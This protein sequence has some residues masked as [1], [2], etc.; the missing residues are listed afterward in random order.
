MRQDPRLFDTIENY[1]RGDLN[2]EERIAFERILAND[3]E[4]AGLV[5]EHRQERRALELIVEQDL[6]AKMKIWES[7]YQAMPSAMPSAQPVA[8]TRSI[9]PWRM[10]I[11]A[12]I[13]LAFGAWWFFG[14][15]NIA[16][17]ELP[18]T[19]VET[20]EVKKPSS[21]VRP[22]K[23]KPNLNSRTAP[24]QSVDD[25]DDQTIAATEPAPPKVDAPVRPTDP[26]IQKDRDPLEDALGPSTAARGTVDYRQLSQTYY[27]DSDFQVQNSSSSKG[28]G[29][30]T[31][32]WDQATK[33]YSSGD[34]SDVI[35]TLKPALKLQPNDVKGKE[36]MA[37]ALYKN[38]NYDE[39]AKY[40]R[41]LARVSDRTVSQRAEWALVLTL[42]NR[43]PARQSE[44]YRVLAEI[45]NTP[46][47]PFAAKAKAL[48]AKL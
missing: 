25:D 29:L 18:I 11:A 7:G 3:A 38:R 15:E 19:K 6:L 33:N 35:T 24:T 30:E 31:S 26:S 14:R 34:Y 28:S 9:N 23:P 45:E 32:I 40:F 36:M 44:L 2:I 1:L 10:G 41:E 20:P 46:G 47:H 27:Q 8:R 16:T 43:M 39:A 12:A 4:L 42:L 48:K 17:D 21:S 37:H 5:Q 13:A 22:A